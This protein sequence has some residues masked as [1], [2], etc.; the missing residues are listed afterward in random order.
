MYLPPTINDISTHLAGK[1]NGDRLKFLDVNDV[2]RRFYAAC[3][4]EALSYMHARGVAYR[5]LK[6]SYRFK[7][8]QN[9][10]RRNG[11][12]HGGVLTAFFMLLR[13]LGMIFFLGYC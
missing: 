2:T 13:R 8:K 4:L 12:K 9:R 11:A 10:R 5:D 1:V 7:E 3:V 6:V